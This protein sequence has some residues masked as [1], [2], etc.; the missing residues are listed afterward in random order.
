[1]ANIKN[2]SLKL[3]RKWLVTQGYKNIRNSGGHEILTRK[4][5]FRPIVLQTQ[6]TPVP[7][8]I[9]KQCLTLLEVDIDDFLKQIDNL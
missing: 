1:M 7:L 3:F 6:I 4:D 8:R 2:I 5:L 9:I